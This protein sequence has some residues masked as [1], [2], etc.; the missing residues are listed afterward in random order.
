[1]RVHARFFDIARV[2]LVLALLGGCRNGNDPADNAAA[3]PPTGAAGNVGSGD[4]PAG[5]RDTCPLTATEVGDVVGAAV[6][7]DATICMFE[8]APGKEPRVLYVR[9]VSFACS[10]T[11][12]NDSSFFLEPYDGLSV[13]AY[14]SS[15]SGELLV[16]TNPPFEITVDITPDLADVIAD[17][18]AASAAARA[19]ERAAAEQLARLILAR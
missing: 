7:Q 17:S 5:P 6:Q 1:M 3:E 9:Q 16:C 11:V 2:V 8:P 12:V 18:N 19:S 10:D 13:R 14:A 4:A 15:A